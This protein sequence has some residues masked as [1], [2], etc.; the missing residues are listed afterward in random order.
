LKLKDFKASSPM[1][2]NDDSIISLSESLFAFSDSDAGA[3]NRFTD[4]LLKE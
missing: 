1:F 4:L 2:L 3:R